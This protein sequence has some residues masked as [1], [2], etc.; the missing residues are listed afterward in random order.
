MLKKILFFLLLVSFSVFG[1]NKIILVKINSILTNDSNPKIR[2]YTINYQ[3]EN[4]TVKP[5]MFFLL[6]KLL[7]PNVASKM[8]LLPIYKIYINDVETLL[9]GPFLQKDAIEWE[10]VFKDLSDY[11]S[12][13][14]QT[15][16]AQAYDDVKAINRVTVINY[17]K[18]GGLVRDENWIIENQN[19]LASKITLNPKEIRKFTIQTLWNLERYFTQDDIEYLLDERDKYK[20]ELILNLKKV[21][22]KDKLS[23]EEYSIIEKDKN[24]IEGVFISNKVELNFK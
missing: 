17:K 6:P 7:V 1:Q 13:Q 12:E 20:F 5:V 14:A 11:N 24:F 16:T 21:A 19:L 8:T 4:T 9:D 23:A 10:N 22:F 2:K 18:N 15:L 3:I